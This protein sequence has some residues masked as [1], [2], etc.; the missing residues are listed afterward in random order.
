MR[1]RKDSQIFRV[2]TSHDF[3]FCA[4][5]LMKKKKYKAAAINNDAEKLRIIPQ[6]PH[7]TVKASR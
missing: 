6:S 5:A 1:F 3:I 2:T 4:V 7:P